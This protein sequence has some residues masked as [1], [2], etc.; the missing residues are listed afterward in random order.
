MAE[1]VIENYTV[2]WIC[3]LQEE[4]EAACRMLDDEFEPPDKLN[5]D[6]K[7]DNIYEYGMINGHY[8]VI[9]C[10]PSGR[11]G[12]VSAAIVAKDMARSFPNLRFALMVGIGGGA[13]TLERDVRLG[14]VVV[15]QPEGDLGGVV[16]FDL[17]KRFQIGGGIR[18]NGEGADEVLFKRTGQLNSPPAVLLGAM[19]RLLRLHRD[20]RKPDKLAEH[21]KLMDDM[22]SFRRP[23]WDVLYK[24]HYLHQS[25]GKT[26][27]NCQKD[28][29]VQRQPRPGNREVMIHYGTIASSNMLMENAVERDRYAKELGV[30]CFEMEAAG[31]MN[32]LP[33]LVIRGICSYSDSHKNDEWNNYAALTA[34]AY[35]KE[36]LS[37]VRH[38]KVKEMP[39]WAGKFQISKQMVGAP[40]LPPPSNIQRF[41]EGGPSIY[42]VYT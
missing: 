9:G 27:Q 19:P 18:G 3:A 16:Q 22:P 39:S 26:C 32:N 6:I 40:P 20:T 2:G 8:V 35:A 25:A 13:P 30:I 4:Y 42:Q 12:V 38:A 7:D 1:S 37:T 10:L 5:I 14:D 21:I 36:L 24:T 31:L 33:C 34:A 17:G 15:S 41:A 28:Q 23:D 29:I 11:S